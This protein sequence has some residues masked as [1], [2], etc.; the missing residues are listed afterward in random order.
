MST[1]S[2]MP[3]TNELRRCLYA[4]MVAAPALATVA[5]AQARPSMAEL[6]IDSHG[7]R[8]NG[9][10][11]L[12]AGKGPQPI[13][14]FLHGFPGN[15]RNLDLAQAVRRAGYQALFI[16]YRGNWG[17]GGTF[18]FANALDDLTAI[19]AW[20]RSPR[21]AAKYD[22]DTRHIA[23]V[24][25]SMGGWLA[26]MSA[27]KEPAN[28]CI[29]AI[30]AWNIGRDGARFASHPDELK[31]NLDY[32]RDV[33]SPGGP[34]HGNAD[35]LIAEMAAGDANWDYLAQ[36]G[37]LSTHPLLLVSATRDSPDENPAMY[38]LLGTALRSA[39][40]RNVT[41]IVYDDDH[42]LSAHRLQLAD[43]L[44]RWLKTRCLS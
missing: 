14:I 7:S 13:V 11:Y 42:A 5:S 37:A 8:L 1:P 15:E 29:A 19:L 34:I 27:G 9:L 44:V 24:G 4:F 18:S 16:D 31:S 33:T 2:R 35:S 20:A 17:A 3:M 40:A 10:I 25:H 6:S 28:A 21:I 32:F 41:S 39:G 36:A 12:A 26:L 30:A 43:A 38:A 23:L 22:I